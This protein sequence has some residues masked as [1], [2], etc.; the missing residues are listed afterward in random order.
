MH[1]TNKFH[2][3]QIVFKMKKFIG[4]FS[5]L[6]AVL[7]VSSCTKDVLSGNGNTVTETRTLPAFTSIDLVGNRAAEFIYSAE[8][9]VELTGYENLL[10]SFHEKVENGKLSFEYPGHTSVRNDNIRLK[11]YTPHITKTT[12]VGNTDVRIGGGF[13]NID[14]KA[15]LAGN[16]KLR[17]APNHFNKL[18]LRTSGNAEVYAEPVVAKHVDVDV[19]GNAFIEVRATERI[20]IQVSGSGE[21]NYWGNPADADIHISGHGHAIRH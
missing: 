8:S 18:E 16:G 12:L 7:L 9:K 1:Y 10:N 4:L 17:F 5:L 19:S 2:H 20:S 14:F 6:S 11:I 3:T 13:N 15:E 21:V